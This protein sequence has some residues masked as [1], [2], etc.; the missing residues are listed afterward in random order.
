MNKTSIAVLT[1][2][3][4]SLS[5][6]GKGQGTIHFVA[7]GSA[8]RTA[9]SGPAAESAAALSGITSFKVCIKKVELEDESG[10][11]QHQEGS[12][13]NEIEFKPGLVDLTSVASSDVTIGALDN[14]PVGFKISKIKI[15]VRQDTSLCGAG[16]HAMEIVNGGSTV[17]TDN[18]I[19]FK[20]KFNPAVDLEGG[21]TINLAFNEFVAL[22]PTITSSGHF[23]SVI[24]AA[25][26]T[27][28]VKNK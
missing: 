23:A 21:D 12:E 13:E 20:W 16:T 11:A 9:K 15:K 4:L 17:T 6:C 10:E 24:P 27:A 5:S 2:L 26:G 14:A 19:E 25:E 8:S 3:A 18:E 28:R 22:L 7:T 1:G